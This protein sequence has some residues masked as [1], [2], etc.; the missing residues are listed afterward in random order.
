MWSFRDVTNERRATRRATFLAAASKVLAG[1]LDDVTPLDVIA[2][3]SVPYLGEWTNI[4]LVE[5]DGSISIAAACHS[6]SSKIP[7]VRRLV[8]DMRLSDHGVARVLTSGEPVVYNGITDEELA[9][10][11]ER[12]VVS[13]TARE[14]LDILRELKLRSYMAVP[15]RARGQTVGAMT[16]SRSD[17]QRRFDDEDLT[18]ATDLAQ[19]AAL[20]IENQR[21]Y[22]ASKEAVELREEF[23]SVASHELRTP[24]TSLQLAVQSLLA[25]GGDA[26]ADFLRQALESAERQTRRLGRLVDALLDVSR[27]QAG[28]L[29]LTRDPTDLVVITREI[30]SIL[31]E[32]ARARRLRHRDRRRDRSARRAL[33]PGAPRAGVTNLVNAMKYGAG[34][35]IT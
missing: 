18:L 6:D 3:L 31:A 17:P 23:L 32:D 28:R 7:L 15:L 21:L 22:R 10:V 25:V 29:E 19:R 33:G 4:L 27:I 11:C 16:F 1:P 5:H 35:P 8:P 24:V 14:Q 20:S 9:G 13:L 26:P 34:A 12:G 2:R 30:A